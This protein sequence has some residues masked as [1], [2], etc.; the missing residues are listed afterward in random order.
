MQLLAGRAGHRAEFG[1][2]LAE[3]V[4]AMRR[5]VIHHVVQR[6]VPRASLDMAPEHRQECLGLVVR[7]ALHEHVAVAMVKKGQYV[8][9]A[10]ADVLELLKALLHRLGLQV[11]GQ[12][13]E[14]LD[15]RTLVEEEQVGGR[16][17]VEREEAL[18]LGEEIRV[19][20]LE[21]VARLMRFQP[22]ALQN[23]MQ[24]RL[25]RR[26]ADRARIGA[27]SALGPA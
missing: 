12:A 8:Q 21:K 20:D 27:Q 13:L 23:P 25:S 2:Q 15:A 6:L 14:D 16:I 11:R 4:A 18:H 3:G 26:R 1:H 5:E 17:V 9:G 10:M 19:G 24:R 7:A 22:I